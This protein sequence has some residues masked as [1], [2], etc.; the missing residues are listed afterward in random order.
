[1]SSIATRFEP[2]APQN[3]FG[4]DDSACP[5]VDYIDGIVL[6][7]Q[8]LLNESGDLLIVFYYQHPRTGFAILPQA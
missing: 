1:M 6:L 5:I 4:L 7:L 3:H 2:K 8:P